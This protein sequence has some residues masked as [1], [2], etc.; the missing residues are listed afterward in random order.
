LYCE[1]SPFEGILS[2]ISTIIKFFIFHFVII[3]WCFAFIL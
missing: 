3:I 2:R 1:K